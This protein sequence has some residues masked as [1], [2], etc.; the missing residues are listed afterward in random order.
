MWFVQRVS[1]FVSHSFRHFIQFW[2]TVRPQHF[3][4]RLINI[5]WHNISMQKE[6][7]KKQ[8][9]ETSELWVAVC[10]ARCTHT[11][12]KQQTDD[13]KNCGFFGHLCLQIPKWIISK[14]GHIGQFCLI[15]AH[16]LYNF[17]L[18]IF[19]EFIAIPVIIVLAFKQNF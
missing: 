14:R 5:V 11:K 13:P 16:A 1:T 12:K 2:N 8:Q 4:D 3:R 10:C 17:R 15:Y 9:Y 6:Q 19:W 18:C 7:K